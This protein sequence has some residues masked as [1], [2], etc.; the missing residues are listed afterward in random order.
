[1][2]WKFSLAIAI[3]A[4]AFAMTADAG[5]ASSTGTKAVA[6]Y[7][8]ELHGSWIPASAVCPQRGQP[9][10]GD[11]VMHISAELL[12]GY[13][14]QSTPSAVAVI[15]SEPPAWR[16]ESLVDVGPSGV[17]ER[18]DPKIFVLSDGN[19]SVTSEFHADVYRKCDR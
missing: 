5:V 17:Y 16:I 3:S 12:Q 4:I 15:S 2:N 10:D 7:P 11:N 9:L 19:L 8:Q 18:G 13:E 1:M 14:D 6:S